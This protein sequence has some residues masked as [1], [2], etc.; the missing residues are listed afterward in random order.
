MCYFRYRN[1]FY[2]ITGTGYLAYGVTGA[3]RVNERPASNY[4]AVFHELM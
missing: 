1:L 4:V 2:H 3:D